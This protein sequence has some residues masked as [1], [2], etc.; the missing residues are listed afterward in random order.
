MKRLRR[1]N[2]NRRSLNLLF[3][4]KEREFSFDSNNNTTAW[5]EEAFAPRKAALTED[6]TLLQ[7]V[8]EAYRKAKKI[9]QSAM[10]YYQVS[11]EWIPVYN[12]CLKDVMAALEQG[13][14]EKLGEIYRNFMRN[15]CSAGLVG[16]PVDMNR[17]Y[18]S[19]NISNKHKKL[20]LY[21]SLHRFWLWKNL[22]G[23]TADIKS[24]TS[25]DIGNPFGY[26]IDGNFIKTGSD[27]QHYYASVIDRLT[28]S[29]E[30][31]LVVEL[32]GGYGGMAYYLI[33]D[34]VNLTYVD[35]DLPENLA[36]ASFYLLSAFPDKKILLFGEEPVPDSR[37]SEYDVV[38]MPNFEIEKMSDLCADM[39]FNSYS[40]AEM[41]SEAVSN[42]ISIF[43]RIAK[44]YI[45]HVNHTRNSLVSAEDFGVDHHQ[46][47]LIYKIP[48]LWNAG[49]NLDMDEYEYL[50]KRTECRE[51]T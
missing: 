14:L 3:D 16:L 22:S 39:V 20:Y 26:Y 25:P 48:A 45:F 1:F 30:R 46:F 28:K 35:Y 29:T 33:R 13:D 23:K 44:K 17:C 19:G 7:R 21:D 4:L 34:G 10:S 15:Q 50:Y 2:D 38:L 12:S 51:D 37:L 42:Y 32:G 47:G 11:N 6:S 8:V 5:V 31:R 49:R 36:L 9:Q 41:S 24:L 40:L 27:Y 18:F 43:N